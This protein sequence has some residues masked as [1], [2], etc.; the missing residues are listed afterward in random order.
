MIRKIILFV[1]LLENNDDSN[2]NFKCCYYSLCRFLCMDTT[3][4]S[5][6]SVLISTL[7]DFKS[8]L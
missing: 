6:P 4:F 1:K 2:N 3:F 5:S 8:G 7:Y